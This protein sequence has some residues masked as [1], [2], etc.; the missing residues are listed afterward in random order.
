MRVLRYSLLAVAVAVVGCQRTD[1]LGPTSVP[2]PLEAPSSL[3][4]VSLNGAIDLSWSDNSYASDPG[5]FH[6]YRVYS[7]SYNLDTG[8]SAATWSIEGTT[9]SPEFLVPTPPTAVPP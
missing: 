5:R 7:T 9:V 2:L 1:L 8:R 3:S 4:S 6:S